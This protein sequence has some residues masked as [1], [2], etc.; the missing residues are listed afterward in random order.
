[1]KKEH[2]K[3]MLDNLNEIV[4]IISVSTTDILE[5]SKEITN[6]DERLG[7]LYT[8]GY[9]QKKIYPLLDKTRMLVDK[10]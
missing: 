3:M 1:M 4:K 9:L 10:Y 6:S 5:S 2:K 7:S 8:I